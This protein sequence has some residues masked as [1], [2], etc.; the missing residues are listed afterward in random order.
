M[1]IRSK[2]ENLQKSSFILAEALRLSSLGTIK[3][4]TQSLPDTDSESLW[5]LISPNSFRIFSSIHLTQFKVQHS[6]TKESRAQVDSM[7]QMIMPKNYI[8]D[9]KIASKIQKKKLQSYLI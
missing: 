7:L 8:T 3:F 5:A 9:E 2:N 6:I 4:S 1:S